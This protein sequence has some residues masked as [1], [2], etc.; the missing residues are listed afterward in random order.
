MHK[1]VIFVRNTSTER[2]VADALAVP[3]FD[4]SARLGAHLSSIITPKRYSCNK[5]ALLRRACQMST[6]TILQTSVPVS[7]Q[8]FQKILTNI[9]IDDMLKI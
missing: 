9:T 3:F 1:Y 5:Q 8:Y 6:L 4:K 2:S 7:G